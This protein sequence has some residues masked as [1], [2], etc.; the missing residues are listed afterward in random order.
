MITA[1]ALSPM[2]GV[3]HAFFTREGGVSEGAFAS[4][5][6]GYGSGDDPDRVAANRAQAMG[7][8]DAG[9]GALVTLHQV[10]SADVAVV[11]APWPPG[12]APTADAAVTRRPGMALG[13]LTAD[14]APVLMADAEAGVIGAAHAGWRGTLK[15]VIEAAVEAMCGLGAERGRIAAAIGPC[16]QQRSYEV[17]PELRDRFVDAD[18][19]DAV[20]FRDAP[21]DGRFLF[22]LSGHLGRR[23]RG[24]GVAVVER[25][26]D[27]TCADEARFFS[28]RRALRAGETDY[29]RGLAA[30]VLGG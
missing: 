6:C 20:F 10:H 18:A 5:N 26:P 22:D 16:I 9:D 25:A 28:Y 24:L 4:L 13:V 7:L 21:R 30:I 3:R 11:E 19:Q 2:N 29:G 12:E 15:G 27:D 17:G 1:S 14:C 8:L 23:L